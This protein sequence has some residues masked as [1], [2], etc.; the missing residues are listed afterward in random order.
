MKKWILKAI[1]QK[2]ISYLPGGQRIN[3]FFQKYVTRGVN[4]SDEYFFDRLSH[5]RTH[6]ESYTQLSPDRALHNALE[7]GTGWYPVVPIGYFLSGV[8]NITTIDI[9]ALLTKKSLQI[10]IKRFLDAANDEALSYYLNVVPDKLIVLKEVYANYEKL[11]FN[12]ILSF[13][14][15]KYLLKDARHTGLTAK[16]FDIISS[17]NTFEHIYPEILE[18]ILK[19]FKR[20]VRN[21]GIMSHAID[22]SD[23]FAHF[24]R[25]INVF[26]FLRYSDKQWKMIDN[27]IQPQNRLRINNFREI[28]KKL[29]IPVTIEKVTHGNLHELAAIPLNDKY[30][31]V[32]REDM[33][34]IQ[35]YFASLITE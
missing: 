16:S 5:A 18:G 30:S 6:I 10:A 31:L 14:N 22:M 8:N 34:V 4:L 29:D 32:S 21:G 15:I 13:I 19:E 17:N 33:A 28:Y 24:D 12:E 7:L 23:H 3:Y 9:S 26:N 1:V 25:S 20:L 2:A 11:S 35:C 27:S